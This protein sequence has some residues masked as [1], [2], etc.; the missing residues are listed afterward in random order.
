MTTTMT[1]IPKSNISS[2]QELRAERQ[3]LKIEIDILES[4]LK[5]QYSEVAD[6]ARSVGHIFTTV[7]KFGSMFSGGHHGDSDDDNSRSSLISNAIKVAVPVL[8]G[9]FF[10]KRKSKLILKSLFGYSLG[11]ATKV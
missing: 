7:S 1:V 3:R 6:K 9:G 5:D 4:Q 8:A 11:Q 2:M 10:I